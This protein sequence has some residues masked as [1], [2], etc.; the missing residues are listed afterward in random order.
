MKT[1]VTD[2]LIFQREGL[3]ISPQDWQRGGPTSPLKLTQKKARDL[4]NL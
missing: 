1:V 4:V 2:I 3:I